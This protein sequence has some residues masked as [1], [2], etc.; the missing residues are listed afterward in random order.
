MKI[1]AFWYGDKEKK[2]ELEKKFNELNAIVG[3]NHKFILGP[4]TEEHEYL[5]KTFE[6]YKK[7]CLAKKYSY[8]AD[9][10]RF[11]KLSKNFGMYMDALIGVNKSKI[12]NFLDELEKNHKSFVLKEDKYYVH[13]CL[14]YIADY[15]TQ[16]VCLETIN[17]YK[18]YINIKN[19]DY[20]ELGPLQFTQS[21]KE[22]NLFVPG[23]KFT[24]NDFFDF[25]PLTFI[26]KEKEDNIFYYSFQASWKKRNSNIDLKWKKAFSNYYKNKHKSFLVG[27][28][29]YL[30]W[31]NRVFLKVLLFL[32]S[33]KAFYRFKSLEIK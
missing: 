13:S 19:I 30:F 33:L 25:L 21:F 8:M 10:Y 12:K 20:F 26:D 18:K 1:Y 14:F 28:Y 29:G 27:L 7:S 9:I 22:L 2:E 11:W 6:Y 15:E 5:L 17:R 4:T 16:K 32:Y 31:H 23:F 3:F 24:Q